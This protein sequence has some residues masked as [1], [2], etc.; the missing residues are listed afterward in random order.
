MIEPKQLASLPF[1]EAAPLWLESHRRHISERT[2][3]D[4]AKWIDMLERFFG[5]LPLSEIGISQMESYQSAR[6]AGEVGG[7]KKRKAGPV[8]I[9]HELRVLAQIL[10]RAGLWKELD[11]HYKPLRIPRS[12]RGCALSTADETRLFEV[13][14]S[15]KRWRVAYLCAV[16][17]LAT[18]PGRC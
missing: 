18:Y 15:K 8:C 4:Y 13:L 11:E 7:E 2:A 1:A 9:N 17:L 14:G 6:M 3:Y 16:N 5:T 10:K 12:T